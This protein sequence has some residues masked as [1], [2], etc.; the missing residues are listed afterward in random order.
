MGI[1][2]KCILR[3]V[4]VPTELGGGGGGGGGKRRRGTNL[5]CIKMNI[6]ILTIV[7]T[8]ELKAPL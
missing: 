5:L 6:I 3:R 2:L 1:F 8:F 7:M 4:W